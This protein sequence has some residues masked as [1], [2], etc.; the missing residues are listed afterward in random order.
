[1]TIDLY[2]YDTPNGH[3]A[4][5]VLEEIGLPYNLHIVDIERATRISTS[6]C[7]SSCCF[8]SASI[9]PG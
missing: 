2:T 4:S 8:L 5:I 3:K 6:C 9:M 1:M 7:A